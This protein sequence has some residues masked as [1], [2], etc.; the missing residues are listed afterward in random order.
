MSSPAT[1]SLN[2]SY[3]SPLSSLAL[4]FFN[5]LQMKYICLHSNPRIISEDALTLNLNK[6]SLSNKMN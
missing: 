5:L 2:N 6:Y 3:I 1:S 4:L